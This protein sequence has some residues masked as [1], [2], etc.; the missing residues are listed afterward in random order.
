[1]SKEIMKAELD[2]FKRSFFQNSI[3]SSQLVQFFPVSAINSTNNL[4][5]YVPASSECFIDPE[6]IFLWLTLQIV[7]SDGTNYNAS[8]ND[9]YSLI[10]YGLMTI[11]QQLDIS[12]NNTLVT[13]STNT[14]AYSSY[15]DALTK[16]DNKAHHT[17]LRSSGYF[18]YKNNLTADEI[19]PELAAL[20]NESKKFK[21]YG[22][23]FNELAETDRYLVN[24]VSM[25]FNFIAANQLFSLMGSAAKAASVSAGTAALSATTPKL[26]ILDA[27][28]FV[29]HIKLSPGVFNSINRQLQTSN[30]FYP[31]KRRNTILFNL[32]QGQSSFNI[33]N[34]FL[35]NLP[36]VLTIGLVDHDSNSG[37]YLLNPLAFKNFGLNHICV[38]LNNEPYPKIPYKPDYT[39]NTY[40]REYFDFHQEQGLTNGIGILDITYHLYKECSNLYFFNFNQDSS[41]SNKDYINLSREGTLRVEIKFD[42][43]LT[44]A[45]KLVCFGR[46]NSNIE[47]D[48]NRN[49]LTDY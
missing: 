11:F 32:S 44:S 2:L 21:L 40:E 9:R 8:Q 37:S 4:E 12:L 3:E 23:V 48:R 43:D 20:S 45:L 13:Q 28:L 36:D 41:N 33:D 31:I 18:S 25:R 19:N 10:N 38:Y 27:S 47:L 22:R 35:G 6:N 14:F 26:K 39:S 30:V 15:L 24:G 49:V 16:N 1:M 5:F 34:V 17:F 7:K 42:A 29:R 46:F